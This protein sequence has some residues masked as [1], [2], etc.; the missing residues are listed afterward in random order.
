MGRSKNSGIFLTY[1][2]ANLSEQFRYADFGGNP[3]FEAEVAGCERRAW[4]IFDKPKNSVPKTVRIELDASRRPLSEAHKRA[5]KRGALD[6]L[7]R[8]D[9]LKSAIERDARDL[10]LAADIF[11]RNLEML[12]SELPDGDSVTIFERIRQLVS[13]SMKIAAIDKKIEV[14]PF[15]PR[16]IAQRRASKKTASGLRKKTANEKQREKN[17][18]ALMKSPKNKQTQHDCIKAAQM[19]FRSTYPTATTPGRSTVY[20]W[21]AEGASHTRKK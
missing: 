18:L 10:L 11:H 1:F 7:M 4:Q 15:E 14:R 21:L 13:L 8:R 12:K 9:L 5:E 19:R 3:N 17:F 6:E 2:P 16:V 20:G